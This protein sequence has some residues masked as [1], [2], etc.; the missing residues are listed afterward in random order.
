VH[1][2][3]RGIRAYVTGVSYLPVYVQRST[4]SG[5]T[6]YRVLPILP[7]A[8]LD[9]DTVVT[10][11]DQERMVQVWNDLREI[12]YRPDEGISPLNP[13]DLGL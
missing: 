10:E 1:I 13:R 11:V 7:G 6:C 2:E 3:K 5:P 12:L 9:T 8:Q 4:L